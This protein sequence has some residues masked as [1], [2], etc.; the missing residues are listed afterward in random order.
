MCDNIQLAERIVADLVLH[1]GL[2]QPQFTAPAYRQRLVVN[3]AVILDSGLAES[4]A[5]HAN[6]WKVLEWYADPLH[7]NSR[8][9]AV[10]KDGGTRAHDAIWPA[11]KK[12]GG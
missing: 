4:R 12:G 8:F 3:I 2:D 7:Y 10:L 5:E 9:P 1:H 6:L 11:P